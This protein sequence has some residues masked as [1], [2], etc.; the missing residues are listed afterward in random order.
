MSREVKSTRVVRKPLFQR[1]PQSIIGD[2]DPNFVYRF[3]NDTGNRIANFKQAGYELVEDAE[4]VVGDSRVSDAGDLGSSKRVVSNDGTTSY[5]MKI[6]R[7]WYEEDQRAKAESIKE[8]E[9]AMTKEAAE[10]RYGSLKIN[11]D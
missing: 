8:Q 7:E 1:G 6:K 9:L 10:G 2:K 11:R 5:L 4:L 3:V